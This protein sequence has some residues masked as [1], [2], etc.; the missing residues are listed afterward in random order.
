MESWGGRK[1]T[2]LVHPGLWP[3][4]L[5]EEIPEVAEATRIWERGDEVF[6]YKDAAFTEKKT[7]AADSN[8]FDVFSFALIS[9]DPSTALSKPN[10]VVL[11]QSVAKKYFSEGDGVGELM[12]IG[13]EKDTYTVTG[14]MEDVPGNS[15]LKFSALFSMNTYDFP[16]SGQWLSNS[17]Y[18]YYVLNEGAEAATVDEKLLPI[19]DRNVTPA[20]KTVF[21]THIRG[22]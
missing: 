11:T 2:Q 12:T 10:S 1:C 21:G 8:F 13:N 6:R 17:F 9:G 20:L 4:P 15:H 7:V 14:V 22:I 5:V 18:T 3:R 19:V 16:S